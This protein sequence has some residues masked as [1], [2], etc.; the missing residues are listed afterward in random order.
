MSAFIDFGMTLSGV[1]FSV[2]EGQY[3]A[4]FA[5]RR[6]SARA[7]QRNHSRPWLR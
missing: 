6:R 5:V 3:L 2:R 4:E 7:A 1:L